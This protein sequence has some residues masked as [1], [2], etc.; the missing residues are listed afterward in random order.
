MSEKLII[1]RDHYTKPCFYSIIVKKINPVGWLAVKLHIAGLKDEKSRTDLIN[2]L[3]NF[4][5]SFN[6]I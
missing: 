3:G 1:P 6:T 2:F 4:N 5:A